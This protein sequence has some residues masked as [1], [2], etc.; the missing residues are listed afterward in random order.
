MKYRKKW[1]CCISVV[2]LVCVILMTGCGGK[3]VSKASNE[4]FISVVDKHVMTVIDQS[5]KIGANSVVQSLYLGTKGEEKDTRIQIEFYTIESNEACQDTYT[6][7]VNQVTT[8]YSNKPGYQTTSNGDEEFCASTTVCTDT[9]Y[10]RISRIEDTL[11][12]GISSS[13]DMKEVDDI[14]KELGY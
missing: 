14:F 1:F 12:V 13:A 7:L 9:K 4:K 10:Y 8:S 6:G 11:L 2:F 5:S 3:K